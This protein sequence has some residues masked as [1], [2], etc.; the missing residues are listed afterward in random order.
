MAQN[1]DNSFSTI[2]SSVDEQNPCISKNGRLLFVTRSNHPDNMGGIKDPGDIWISVRGVSGW[3]APRHGG[4]ILNDKGYNTI[5][6]TSADG[7]RVLASH[8]RTRGD[9]VIG[10][11]LSFYL[12]E[13]DA[14]KMHET[15]S[16]PYF[17]TRSTN[18]QG[19]LST[20]GNHLVYAADTY[21]TVGVEDLYVSHRSESGWSEPQN[22][23]KVINTPFQ[24]LAPS[25]SAHDD[26]LFF[27]S[28]GRKGR[29]SFDV[30][31]S[32]R[33][34][35]D[36]YE[37]SE[38]VNVAAVNT[39]GRELFYKAL[40]NGSA[41]FTSTRDSD[42]YG[43][44]RFFDSGK[45][46]VV[47]TSVVETI[48]M[49]DGFALVSGKVLDAKTQLPLAARLVFK[50]DAGEEVVTGTQDGYKSPLGVAEYHV[51]V[52]APGY[53]SSFQTVNLNSAPTAPVELNFQLYPIEKGVTVNLKNVLFKQSSTELM[54]GSKEELDVVASFLKANA[55]V[56]IL[57]V[58]HTDN[59]GVHADNV[60]LSQ[61]R[62]EKV[63]D[64]LVM[65]G[66]SAKRIKGK[67][68]GGVQP[69]AGNETDEGRKL[70]RRVEFTISRN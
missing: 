27:S 54:P 32:V 36:W 31:F 9:A 60:R 16:I 55:T 43:D 18:V 70:N 34:S 58:G 51:T 48:R 1:G 24:E 7:S 42:G 8:V 59:R 13:G 12:L 14:W 20:D 57:L 62:V 3:E 15:L 50:S 68:I 65:Q 26:T 2:N 5:L 10:Q 29:G 28:N 25:L 4:V 17:H 67:G 46:L 52:E 35:D 64:Y 40:G 56:R 63:K 61:A 22:L 45:P 53:V 23:G 44:L 6:G 30:Y 38:P 69:I 33:Q 11:G 39:D 47:D 21:G 37:W 49:R 41:L 19:H 66:I